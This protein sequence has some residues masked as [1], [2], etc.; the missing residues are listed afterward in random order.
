MKIIYEK[1]CVLRDLGWVV[2]LGVC[3]GVVCYVDID[4]VWV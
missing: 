1:K 4:L 2:I 3:V